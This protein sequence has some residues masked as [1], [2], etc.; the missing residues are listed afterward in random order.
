MSPHLWMITNRRRDREN[1]NGERGPL[2][3]WIADSGDPTIL[4]TWTKVGATAFKAHLAQAAD[5]LGGSVKPDQQEDQPHV[6][7]FVHGYNST[8]ADAA[9]RYRSPC[10]GLFSGD[11]SLGL[12]VLFTWPSFGSPVDHLPDRAEACDS[13]S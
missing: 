5:E 10:S 11:A 6:I 7:L 12:C 2:T 9:V 3:Y 13:V 4:T 1:L 8:W